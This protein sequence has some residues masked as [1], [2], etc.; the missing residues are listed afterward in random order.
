M[1]VKSRTLVLHKHSSVHTNAAAMNQCKDVGHKDY[2]YEIE[3][4]TTTKLDADDFIIDHTTVHKVIE[5][6]VQTRMGSCERLCLNVEE[7][8]LAA[9]EEHGCTVK[10]IVFAIKPA[11]SNAWMRFEGEYE[12]EPEPL[13]DELSYYDHMG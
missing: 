4:T 3:I 6:V 11:T 9:L 1:R 5:N 10:K 8:V 12:T 7:D 2:D 13:C